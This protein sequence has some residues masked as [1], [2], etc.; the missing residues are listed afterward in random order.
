MVLLPGAAHVLHVEVGARGML[1]SKQTFDDTE[2][3]KGLDF[4]H[5][6]FHLGNVTMHYKPENNQK[7][8]QLLL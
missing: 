2:A 6:T 4:V 1:L 8:Q 5:Q 7:H 3:C